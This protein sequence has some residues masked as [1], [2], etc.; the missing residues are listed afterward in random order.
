MRWVISATAFFIPLLL[1]VAIG[2][3]FVDVAPATEGGRPSLH[4]SAMDELY[5]FIQGNQELLDH[6]AI[7]P[8]VETSGTVPHLSLER[9]DR[10]GVDRHG[11]AWYRLAQPPPGTRCGLLRR[12]TGDN[13]PVGDIDGLPA[14]V[15]LPLS[16][17]WSYWET[18]P[19]PQA[20][21][22]RPAKSP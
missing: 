20:P 13:L 6:Y 19:P 14:R 12:A 5:R 2:S 10:R 1:I 11:H 21:T 3:C 16:G 8:G 17:S 7:K 18:Q 4:P 15:L 9:F 22:A